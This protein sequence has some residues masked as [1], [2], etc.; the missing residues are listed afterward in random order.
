MS[1]FAVGKKAIA[2]CDRCGQ[3]YKLKELKKLFVNGRQVN[4]KVCP[5]CWEP[6][7]P[8]NL[9]GK[10]PVRDPQALRDPR[11]DAAELE[12]S[13]EIT[14]PGGITVEQYILNMTGG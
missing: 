11:P 12:A 6:D 5:T 14:V 10:Y 7:H 9:L 2:I 13:R 8:Q 3:Q 4:T 1:D